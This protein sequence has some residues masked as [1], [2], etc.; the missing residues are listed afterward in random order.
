MYRN[1]KIKGKAPAAQDPEGTGSV[2]NTAEQVYALHVAA[3]QVGHRREQQVV[4]TAP[5]LQLHICWAASLQ[6]CEE[7]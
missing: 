3:W 1:V 4:H 7:T 2:S 5:P 6:T